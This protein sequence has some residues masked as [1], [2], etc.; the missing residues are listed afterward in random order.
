MVY[1]KLAYTPL[2]AVFVSGRILTLLFVL[3]LVHSSRYLDIFA[4]GHFF[5]TDIFAVATE[6]KKKNHNITPHVRRTYFC[7]VLFV[8]FVLPFQTDMKTKNTREHAPVYRTN[9]LRR[10]PRP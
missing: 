9:S 10:P 8:N 4:I 7:F 6:K 3:V 5:A 1:K 2:L